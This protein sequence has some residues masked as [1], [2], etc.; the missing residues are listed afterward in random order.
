MCP[1]GAPSGT[2]LPG[3]RLTHLWNVVHADVGALRGCASCLGR[4]SQAHTLTSVTTQLVALAFAIAALAGCEGERLYGES[5]RADC[6]TP[7]PVINGVRDA[8]A[9]G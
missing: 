2:A 5:G 9:C 1:V 4:W 8:E 6:A 7:A 3:D